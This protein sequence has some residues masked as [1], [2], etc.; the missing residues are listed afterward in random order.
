[1]SHPRKESHNPLAGLMPGNDLDKAPIYNNKTRHFRY[2]IFIRLFPAIMIEKVKV[3]GAVI[4]T[5]NRALQLQPF[6]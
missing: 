2:D 3:L 5:L 4:F 6:L 1:M